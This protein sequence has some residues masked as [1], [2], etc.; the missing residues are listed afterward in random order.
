[1]NSWKFLTTGF[2]LH[3]QSAASL[4]HPH[5]GLSYVWGLLSLLFCHFLRKHPPPAYM[6]SCQWW[7]T[8]LSFNIRFSCIHIIK[9]CVLISSDF[10]WIQASIEFMESSQPGTFCPQWPLH[11]MTMLLGPLWYV[12]EEKKGSILLLNS[13]LALVLLLFTLSVS[14]RAAVYQTRLL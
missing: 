9:P 1:M 4:D 3:Q 14:Q 5:H 10:F 6:T 11:S 2:I 13:T 8:L 7:S 12:L